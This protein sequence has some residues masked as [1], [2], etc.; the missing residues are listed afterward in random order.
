MILK[1]Q[2]EFFSWKKAAQDLNALND[3]SFIIKV[4][5]KSGNSSTQK[6]T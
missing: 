6:V 1:Y 5:N 4:S 3:T 2:N